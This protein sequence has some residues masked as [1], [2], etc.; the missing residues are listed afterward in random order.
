MDYLLVAIMWFSCGVL[1]CA[2]AETHHVE[3][4][5]MA[6]LATLGTIVFTVV[7]MRER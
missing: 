5:I 6:F 7:V 4:A 2:V 3:T 1:W